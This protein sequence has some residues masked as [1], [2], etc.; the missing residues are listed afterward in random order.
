[1]YITEREV[2]FSNSEKPSCS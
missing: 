1:M 2:T